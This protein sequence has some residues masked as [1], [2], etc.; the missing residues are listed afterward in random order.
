MYK[1]NADVT[2]HHGQKR[3]YHDVQEQAGLAYY[4]ARSLSISET[5]GIGNDALEERLTLGV[6]SLATLGEIAKMESLLPSI[7]SMLPPDCSYS[8]LRHTPKSQDVRSSQAKAWSA[9]RKPIE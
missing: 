8:S 3:E 1:V 6:A 9:I 4:L 7:A 2:G 5:R